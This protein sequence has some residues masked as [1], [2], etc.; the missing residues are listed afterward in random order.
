MGYL[1]KVK[2]NYHGDEIKMFYSKPEKGCYMSDEMII[3]RKEYDEHYS[4]LED[5]DF[6][7]VDGWH[8]T[9]AEVYSRESVGIDI[10]MGTFYL[11]CILQGKWNELEYDK[12]YEFI[13]LS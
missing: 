8:D 2:T 6:V 1:L 10:T 5:N 9:S 4:K 7:F 12:P 13:L 11:D 3:S